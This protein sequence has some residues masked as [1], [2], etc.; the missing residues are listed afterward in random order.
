[1][2]TKDSSVDIWSLE[3]QMQPVLKVAEEVWET[4]LDLEP[5]ITSARD[6]IHS[7]GSLHYYG[8]AVDLRTWDAMGVQLDDEM[9]AIVANALR[10]KLASYSP[11][12]DVVEHKTHIHV[13]FDV[14]KA[15]LVAF[16][17]Y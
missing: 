13:E 4:Y 14:F 6:G 16:E 7:A 3:I 11:Y 1:M 9:R 2:K 12:F 17:A 10:H 15:D 8:Y 5:V